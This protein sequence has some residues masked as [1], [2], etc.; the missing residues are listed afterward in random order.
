M[1]A[2]LLR[3]GRWVIE[4]HP[5]ETRRLLEDRRGADACACEACAR[6]RV[7]RERAWDRAG[8]EM[9]DA[10]GVRLDRAFEVTHWAELTPGEHVYTVEYEFI[11]RVLEGGPLAGA[12]SA[13]TSDDDL[14]DDLRRVSVSAWTPRDADV[15][16]SRP[17]RLHLSIDVIVPWD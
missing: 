3:I 14:L 7:A 16:Q 13:W 9:L 6:Y 4:A 8:R 2:T 12:T 1:E 15:P 17:S 10:L 5:D 11:G